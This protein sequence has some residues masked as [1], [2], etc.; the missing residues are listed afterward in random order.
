MNEKPKTRVGLIILFAFIGLFVGI[1]IGL[2]SGILGVKI[3]DK[4]TN[5]NLNLNWEEKVK[6]AEEEAKKFKEEA[7]KAKEELE[8]KVKDSLGGTY[9]DQYVVSTYGD[10][11]LIYMIYDGKLYYKSA[12]KNFA[13]LNLCPG[14]EDY[15]KGNSTYNNTMTLVSGISNVT[16]VK[17]VVDIAASDERFKIMAINESGNVYDIQKNIA[18]T[19]ISGRN[20]NDLVNLK[21]SGDESYYEFSTTSGKKVYYKWVWNDNNEGSYKIEG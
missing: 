9:K 1:G 20:I 7:Q 3:F 18:K 16:K 10:E 4:A 5:K 2:L 13:G 11:F 6:K 19:I 8:K 21:F 15:C 12:D 14:T 17:M